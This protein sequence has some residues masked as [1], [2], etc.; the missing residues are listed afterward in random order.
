MHNRV[1]EDPIRNIASDANSIDPKVPR[2][3]ML[4]EHRPSHLN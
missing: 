1:Q 3:P 4:N 2:S